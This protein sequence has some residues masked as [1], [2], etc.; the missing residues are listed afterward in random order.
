MLPGNKEDKSKE[1][2]DRASLAEVYTLQEDGSSPF[3]AV[4]VAGTIR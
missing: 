1:Q 2:E 3:P 4:R